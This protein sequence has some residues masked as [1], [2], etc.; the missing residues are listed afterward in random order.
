MSGAEVLMTGTM[1]LY[2]INWRRGNRI[3]DKVFYIGFP[4]GDNRP[5]VAMIR[6]NVNAA[7]AAWEQCH[8]TRKLGMLW[9]VAVAR[10]MSINQLLAS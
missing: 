10:G 4:P 7:I 1:Y 8:T 5:P 9:R 6:N 3:T 2:A